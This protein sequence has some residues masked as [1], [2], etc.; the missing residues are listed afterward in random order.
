MKKL[1][2]ILFSILIIFFTNFSVVFSAQWKINLISGK[3]KIIDGDT[4]K[5]NGNNIRLLGIDAPE[6]NQICFISGASIPHNLIF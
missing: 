5:I 2:Q 6:K 4:I 1:S 3:A